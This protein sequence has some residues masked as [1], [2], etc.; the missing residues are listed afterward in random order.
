MPRAILKNGVLV[1]I[2]PLPA[3]WDDGT[4]VSL[5]KVRTH[6]MPTESID[7]WLDKVNSL[8]AQMSEEDDR[9]L[10]EAIVDIRK[11]AKDLARKGKR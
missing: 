11:E 6:H 5:K 2:T 7:E 8:A 9:R 3:D 4:E 1:P 10:A